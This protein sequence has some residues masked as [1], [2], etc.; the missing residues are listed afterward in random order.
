MTDMKDM[1]LERTEQR[2]DKMIDIIK[3]RQKIDHGFLN[4]DTPKLAHRICSDYFGKNPYRPKMPINVAAASLY[5]ADLALNT[6]PQEGKYVFH[7]YH[8][9]QGFFGYV[10]FLLEREEL[11][12]KD[13]KNHGN[14]HVNEEMSY[15]NMYNDS[16]VLS[17]RSS[18]GIA[19][20]DIL[21][22][23]GFRSDSGIVHHDARYIAEIGGFLQNEYHI[24]LRPRFLG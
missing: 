13:T 23:F 20:K 1:R 7:S 22:S 16:R 12:K 14:E 5:L 8:L 24:S 2:L 6:Y 17:K 11:S 4:D 19:C 21:K 18:V 15:N 9:Q 3:S 10:K